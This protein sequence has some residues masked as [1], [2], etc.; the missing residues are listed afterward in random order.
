MSE[1][2]ML[3]LRKEDSG[4][5]ENEVKQAAE[6]ADGKV[7]VKSAKSGRKTKKIANDGADPGILDDTAQTEQPEKKQ[8]YYRQKVPNEVV[9]KEAALA[10]IEKKTKPKT[11]NKANGHFPNSDEALNMAPGDNARYV[12][13][14]M[15]IYNMTPIDI[16]NAIQVENR[17]QE[18]FRLCIDNDMKPGVA[19]LAMA[20][21]IDRFTLLDIVQDAE[22]RARVPHEVRLSIKKAHAYMGSYWEQIMQN[23]K[24]NPAS[25]IFLGKNNFGYRDQVEHV[26]T[27]NV[28]TSDQVSPNEL[29]RRI[30][31]LPDD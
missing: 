28:K 16:N 4:E 6:N 14:G 20:L 15:A 10:Y 11:S 19:N 26:L 31:A 25:G 2:R 9:R 23:G 5:L 24:I 27:P 29:Q 3:N 17:I 22:T 7:S 21:G 30:E 8:S 12:M 18:Y 13:F 1:N